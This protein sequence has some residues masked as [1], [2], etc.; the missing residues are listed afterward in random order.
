MAGATGGGLPLVLYVLFAV[1]VTGFV[2]YVHLFHPINIYTYSRDVWHHLAVLNALMDSPFDPANPHIATGDSSRTFMPWYVLLALI[3]R[4]FSLPALTVLG[5]SASFTMVVLMS[6]SYL[7]ARTYYK[8]A[9]APLVMWVVM[10]GAWGMNLNYSGLHNFATQVFSIGYPFGIV[11]AAGFFAWWALLRWL[12][13]EKPRALDVALVAGLPAFMFAAHQLQAGFALGAMTMFALFWGKAPWRRRWTILATMA[14][15]M[16]LSAF[17]PYYNPFEILREVTTPGWDVTP[18]WSNPVVIVVF[19]SV[20]LLGLFG[21]Y[22]Y[23]AGR[24]RKEL[25]LGAAAIFI[26]YAGGGTLGNP[27]SHRFLFFLIFFLHLGLVHFLYSARDWA[28]AGPRRPLKTAA[29]S[30]LAAGMLGLF[31]LHVYYGVDIYLK[32]QRYGKGE[33]GLFSSP[34]ISPVILD[35]VRT[36]KTMAPPDAVFIGEAESAYPVQAFGWKV[37]SIPR[38]FPPVPDMRERQQASLAFFDPATT[39]AERWR[40]IETYHPSWII[41]RIKFTA[42]EVMGALR[43]F[44]EETVLKDGLVVIKIVPS[45]EP[46]G[47]GEGS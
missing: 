24:W 44:G 5:L 47:A 34:R 14:A 1:L 38:P 33:V 20:A 41:Y 42:P 30:V 6:G 21:F 46:A 43:A 22:D 2:S 23:A 36:L 12:E 8:D 15:G 7:F 27:I 39:A 10:F 31:T 16:G 13:A 32:Y 37:V 11:L 35:N 28:R 29:F 17:W 26:G 9:W 18:G 45:R 3:G 4:A 25:A 40:I 19:S